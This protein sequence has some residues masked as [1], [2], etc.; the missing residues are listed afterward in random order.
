MRKKNAKSYVYLLHFAQP[1][2][3]GR[4]TAQHYLG[5]ARDLQ[6]RLTEHTTGQGA[7][8]T[9]VALSRGITWELA[10]V[11]EAPATE[12]RKLEKKLKARHNGKALCPICAQGGERVI[13]E[14]VN[15]Y[16]MP[17]DFAQGLEDF[18]KGATYCKPGID[19]AAVESDRIGD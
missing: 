16:P 8:L 10:K 19:W 13:G 5:V 2:A 18:A 12:G 4:H 6:Q 9:Q 11:W 15:F 17:A 7:R 14:D 3:P 1:I